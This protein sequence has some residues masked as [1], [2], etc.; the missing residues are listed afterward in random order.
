VKFSART[1]GRQGNPAKPGCYECKET[2]VEWGQDEEGGVSGEE[3][4][5]V[6]E[7]RRREGEIG[8]NW[9]GEGRQQEVK[10][11]NL[12]GEV[13]EESETRKGE[14]KRE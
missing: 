10:V 3:E 7:D 11:G 14:E 5:G 2:T 8:K 12:R 9:Y 1:G 4:R 13:Q 6:G